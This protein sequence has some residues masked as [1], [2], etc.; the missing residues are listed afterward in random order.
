MPQAVWY[1][2]VVQEF[3]NLR[4]ALFWGLTDGHDIALG[5]AIAGSLGRFWFDGGRSRQGLYWVEHA[6]HSL[7][8]DCATRDAARLHLARAGL[9][10][11]SNKLQAAQSART[12]YEAVTDNRGVGYALRQC[13]LAFRQE[14]RWDEAETAC[15]R[16]VDLLK[17]MNDVGGFA[18]ASNTLGSIVAGRGDFEQARVIHEQALSEASRHNCEYAVMQTLLYIADLDFQRGDYAQAVAHAT[19]ALSS[20]EPS[21]TPGFVANLRCNLVIYRIALDQYA[22]AAADVLETL[23]ILRDSQDSL[24]DR[25]RTA[26]CRPD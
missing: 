17:S 18:M 9:L 2:S 3:E 23:A 22:Q 5:A 14:R 16:A 19:Q 7:P 12:I 13:A 20:A 10:Q 26:A 8:E 24:S 21:R 4:A 11:S 25:N 6:L 1:K 15:R